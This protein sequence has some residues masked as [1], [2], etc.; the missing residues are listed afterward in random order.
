MA[1]NRDLNVA[2]A[3]NG[4]EFRFFWFSELLKMPI[5]VG[6]GQEEAHGSR[7][8]A[9]RALSGRR[10]HLRRARMGEAYGVRALEQG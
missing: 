2:E 1:A 5:R 3:A 7:V 9:G 10:R 8:Q 4:K 6:E